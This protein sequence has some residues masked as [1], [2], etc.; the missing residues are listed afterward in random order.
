MSPP[1]WGGGGCVNISLPDSPGAGLIAEPQTLAHLWT[2]GTD[3]PSWG[4]ARGPRKAAVG[5]MGL[6]TPQYHSIPASLPLPVL[7][8]LLG[9]PL[10]LLGQT[11]TCSLRLSLGQVGL[12]NP[13][14][15][16]LHSVHLMHPDLRPSLCPQHPDRAGL[17]TCQPPAF[18]AANTGSTCGSVSSMC[19]S[20]M[21]DGKH[22]S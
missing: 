20:F 9:V 17:S 12:Q 5:L 21:P 3:C 2:L 14:P 13:N 7:C 18:W 22:S 16:A 10:H 15:S 4:P 1:V 8:P 6:H 11:P 19:L